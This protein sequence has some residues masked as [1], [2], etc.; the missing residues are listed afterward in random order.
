[1]INTIIDSKTKRVYQFLFK[2]DDI[3]NPGQVILCC[4]SVL[5]APSAI[6][7]FAPNAFQER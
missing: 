7:I 5:V 1:M 6:D 2:S 4:A 3:Q